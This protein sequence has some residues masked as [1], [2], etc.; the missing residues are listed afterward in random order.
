MQNKLTSS[1]V[2]KRFFHRASREIL[3]A[4][5][6]K[7]VCFFLQKTENKI[8]HEGSPPEDPPKGGDLVARFRE[9]VGGDSERGECG[10]HAELG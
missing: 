3:T 7:S 10:D 5:D 8:D 1:I 2:T 4:F 9:K 6:I